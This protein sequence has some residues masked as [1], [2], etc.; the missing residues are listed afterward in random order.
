MYQYFLLLLFKFF[1]LGLL[2][3]DYN[4]KLCRPFFHSGNLTMIVPSQIVETENASMAL[5]ALFWYYIAVVGPL[6]SWL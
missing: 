5:K 2:F 1:L 4:L 6:E 3:V